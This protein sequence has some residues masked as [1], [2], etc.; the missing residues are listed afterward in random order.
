MQCPA[1]HKTIKLE[2]KISFREECSHCGGD[3]HICLMCQFHDVSAYNEC[4]ESQAERVLDKAKA[5][6]CDYFQLNN[7][8]NS[9]SNNPTQSTKTQ[10][11]ALFSK[12][13]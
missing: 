8:Q 12:L 3:L 5:N 6:R 11:D 9:S 4:R 2:G 7:S 13:K 10:L 1:C